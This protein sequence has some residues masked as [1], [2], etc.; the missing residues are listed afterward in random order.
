MYIQY[1]PT[2]SHSKMCNIWSTEQKLTFCF[3]T[4][5]M[6]LSERHLLLGVY[7]HIIVLHLDET[8]D[9]ALVHMHAK[10]K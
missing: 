2:H 4:I 7:I 5:A 10:T 1:M 3:L 9:V 8:V 6:I